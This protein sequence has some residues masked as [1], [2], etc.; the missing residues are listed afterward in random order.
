[1][2]TNVRIYLKGMVLHGTLVDIS[3]G[4]LLAE[5]E[6]RVLNDDYSD[7]TVSENDDIT[8]DIPRLRLSRL[9]GNVVRVTG[10]GYGYTIAVK[11]EEIRPEIATRIIEKFARK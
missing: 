4:G 9:G 8:V 11:F 2:V 1:M 6:I 7:V 5:A 3:I 10:A